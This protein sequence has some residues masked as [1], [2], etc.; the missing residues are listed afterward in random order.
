MDYEPAGAEK[1]DQPV[2]PK[3]PPFLLVDNGESRKSLDSRP[4]FP[5]EFTLNGQGEIPLPRLRDQND[6]EGLGMIRR[7]TDPQGL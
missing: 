7:L 1:P 6:S 5:T 2:I 3:S 4:R